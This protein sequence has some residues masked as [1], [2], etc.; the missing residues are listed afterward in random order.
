MSRRMVL[1]LRRRTEVGAALVA[2]LLIIGFNTSS[3]GVW[4][5]NANMR[6]VLRV[7]SILAIMAFGQVLVITT[8]EIDISVGSIFGSVGIT[9]L[10][11]I[12]DVGIPLAI[13]AALGVGLSIGLL[14]G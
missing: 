8:G 4:L 6:E 9:Y 2:L 3:D 5:S 10:A 7:T 13:L 1:F 11:L 14:N 12:P